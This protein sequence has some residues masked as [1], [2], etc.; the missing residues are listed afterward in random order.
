MLT[1]KEALS[2]EREDKTILP[3]GTGTDSGL[4]WQSKIEGQDLEQE[5]ERK[6]YAHNNNCKLESKREKLTSVQISTEESIDILYF[7]EKIKLMF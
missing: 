1:N 2:A 6:N 4:G 7:K 3:K 5:A